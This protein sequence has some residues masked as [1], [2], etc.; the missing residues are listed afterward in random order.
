MFMCV[1]VLHTCACGDCSV[2]GLT[3]L[4]SHG[5]V[6]AVKPKHDIIITFYNNVHGLVSEAELAR[7]VGYW[8]SLPIRTSP[9]VVAG[10]TTH[11]DVRSHCVLS[12]LH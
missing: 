4:V 7:S 5:F 3:A 2:G 11:V 8:N 9:S 1:R 10:V 6:T 12:W